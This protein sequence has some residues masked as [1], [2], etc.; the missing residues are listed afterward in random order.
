MNAF[1]CVVAQ[2]GSDPAV[3]AEVTAVL[4]SVA[5]VECRNVATNETASAAADILVI[6]WA[7]ADLHSLTLL[8]AQCRGRDLSRT[9][10]VVGELNDERALNALLKLG[11]ADFVRLPLSKVELRARVE[12]AL[13]LLA[14]GPEHPV[15]R[16]LGCDEPLLCSVS[17]R[18]N[19][20]V[21]RL[22]V[23]AGQAGDV[24]VCGER[25]TGRR[26]FV[27]QIV[28]LTGGAAPIELDPESC[29]SA[30]GER[31]LSTLLEKSA[32]ATQAA[33]LASCGTLLV[34]HDLELLSERAQWLLL[35]LVQPPSAPSGGGRLRVLA[36]A[37]DCTADAYAPGS[38]L[39]Q[40]IDRL[41]TLRVR[42]PPLRERRDDL[43]PLV[44]LFLAQRCSELGRRV[45]ALTPAAAQY[46]LTHEWG[47]NARE[48]SVVITQ[49]LQSTPSDVLGVHDLFTE[50]NQQNSLIESSLQ[51]TKTQ[52]IVSFERT[53]L[54][55]LLQACQGNIAK[56]ARITQKNRRALF[57]LIRKHEI[58]VEQYRVAGTDVR[59]N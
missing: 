45:P 42:L 26:A 46:L 8:V 5:G 31:L 51:Q 40:L 59:R 10:I 30:D 25:G 32:D 44:R 58:D 18:F 11:V 52:M 34:V 21:A 6:C 14:S 38:P 16:W 28:R 39:A 47:S 54:E 27:R 29:A 23:L 48:L 53:F 2:R 20:Q 19:A 50:H 56:A 3:V 35:K 49:A 17:P 41:S 43:L 57:E 12:R 15:S 7:S 1:R 4:N 36:T 9:V 13:G 55:Q 24:L 22:P 37:A 33:A